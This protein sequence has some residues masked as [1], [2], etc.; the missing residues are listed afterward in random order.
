MHDLH[1]D[2]HFLPER[3]K[4]QKVEKFVAGFHHEKKCFT[5]IKNLKQGLIHGL[6]LKRMHKVIKFNSVYLG[7]FLTFVVR[8]WALPPPPLCSLD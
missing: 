2:L 7:V 5:H 6:V 3:M 4:I 8:G 1:N